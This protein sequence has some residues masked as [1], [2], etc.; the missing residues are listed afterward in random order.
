MNTT[1]AVATNLSKPY[2]VQIRKDIVY[3]TGAVGARNGQ[4]AILRELKLDLYQ[5]ALDAPAHN[6]PALVMAFGGA[7]H[8]GSKEDDTYGKEPQ[9]NN[10][11]AWYCYEF[12]RRGYVAC[13]IDYR[14]VPEDPQP[15]NT[16]V[17][18]NPERFP[19]S[20]VDVVRQIM[21]LPEASDDML[22]RGVEAASDDMALALRYIKAQSAQWGIDPQRMAIGGFSAGA[23]TALNVALGEREPVAAVIALSGYMDAQDIERHTASGQ[24]FPSLLLISAD[25]DLDYVVNHTPDMVARFRAHG[26]HCEHVQVSKATHFYPAN[27]PAVHDS[28]GLT[29]VECAMT[30]FLER[31]MPA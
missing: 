27:S 8:R 9:R 29:T 30:A 5:P 13:S 2:Q 6:R 4:E 25:N 24:S 1:S 11:V 28:R 7:F 18:F 26:V 22:W 14:L 23:R 17:T 3:G 31:A 19:R 15:G 12:A 20:R 10:S 16:P 21:G